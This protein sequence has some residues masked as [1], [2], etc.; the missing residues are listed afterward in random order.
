MQEKLSK[1]IDVKTIITFSLVA[2]MI[3]FT[4]VGRIDAKELASL[5]VMSVSFYFG[6]KSVKKE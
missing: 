5:T 6:T 3:Y 4:A 2:A 1:L